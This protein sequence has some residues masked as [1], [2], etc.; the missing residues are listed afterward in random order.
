MK[1]GH[2]PLNTLV[3]FEGGVVCLSLSP[4]IPDRA[5]RI[6]FHTTPVFA[7]ELYGSIVGI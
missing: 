2:Y 1:F 7:L 6:H 4:V 3:H 5:G